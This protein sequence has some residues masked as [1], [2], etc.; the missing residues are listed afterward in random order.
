METKILIIG[1]GFG[2]LGLAIRLQQSGR[3]DFILLEKA[4]DVG[5]VWRENS[6][7]GAACDVPSHLYSFSF[8]R[9]F[10]WSRTFS[11]R[12]DILR[13]LRHCADR[14]GLRSCIHTGREVTRARFD[15]S[16]GFWHV[17]C[18]DGSEYRSRVLVAATGQLCRPLVPSLPGLETFKGTVFHSAQWRHDYDLR[19]KKV[20]VIGTGASA[21]QFVP[22]IAQQ[23]D[24]L[25]LFQRSPP[26]VLPKPERNYAGFWRGL[27]TWLPFLVT[28][29]RLWIYLQLEY[30]QPVWRNNRFWMWAVERMF[31]KHLQEQVTDPQLQEKLRPDYPMGCKRILISDNYYPALARSNVQLVTEAVA[32]LEEDAVISTSGQ[33]VPVDCV[34]LGTGFDTTHFLAP[35][36]V[37]G[38]NGI[39]LQDAW[40]NGASAY[41]GITVH[42]FPNLFMLYGPNTNLGHNSI[43]YMLESQFSYVL[44][45][46]DRLED[47]HAGPLSLNVRQAVQQAFDQ[48]IQQQLSKTV[49]QGGCR[50]WY[51]DE[52]GRNSNNWPGF[53]FRYRAL[54]RQLD[55]EDYDLLAHP[56]Q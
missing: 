26:Y 11:P 45:A 13:Y 12:D 14:Y 55:L 4:G 36:E 54:T 41:L 23:V 39:T 20:A 52:H 56:A 6:Y 22:E 25:T 15:D 48:D 32:R 7:P 8:E 49:W 42:D 33:R 27:F 28:L 50:S 34:I 51:V 2:G 19:G 30:R 9:H 17:Q 21:I 24:Q 3:T 53:T 47:R 44:S 18:A 37:T 10:D 43:I 31:E 46:L 16:S 1:T 38:L 35:I 29:H 40:K 5:G